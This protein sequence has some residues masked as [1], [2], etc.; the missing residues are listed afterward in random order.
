M[1]ET[2]EWLSTFGENA[3]RRFDRLRDCK[4][5]LLAIASTDEHQA[6]RRRAP[7]PAGSAIRASAA[8][9]KSRARAPRS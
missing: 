7:S 4:Q 9:I 3:Q 5:S 1:R 8:S 6:D 2:A